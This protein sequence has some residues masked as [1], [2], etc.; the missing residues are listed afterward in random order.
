MTGLTAFVKE[1]NRIE[2]ILRAPYK[3]EIDAHERFLAISPGCLH[4]VTVKE[5]VAA[6]APGKP[7]RD[8]V[9][10]NVCVGSHIAPPGS[11]QIADDL[12]EI[13]ANA[14]E[15]YDAYHV[16]QSYEHLHPF[17]DGNGRSGRAL[18]LWQQKHFFNYDRA[19]ALGFLHNW[20]YASLSHNQALQE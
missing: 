14:A 19:L 9:G 4:L 5:F 1:S 7:L 6:V 11:P 10:L 8:K 2:G 12:V 3:A 13:L 16:H 20:Y 18:W 17:M 15:G